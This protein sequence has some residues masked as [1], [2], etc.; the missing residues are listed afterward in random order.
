[1]RSI[2]TQTLYDDAKH[3]VAVQIPYA[4]WL[5]IKAQL[6]IKDVRGT[7]HGALPLR[8]GATAATLNKYA[9]V[10]H[11]SEDPLKYQRGVREEWP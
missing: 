4:D 1:M 9:G 8:P 2:R 11:L 3:P 7:T 5:K 10:L 6:R